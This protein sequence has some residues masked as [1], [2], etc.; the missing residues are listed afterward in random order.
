MSKL[1][2]INNAEN[3]E[4]S[5]CTMYFSTSSFVLNPFQNNKL[6]SSKLKEFADNNSKFDK[7]WH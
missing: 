1:L 5:T 6:D 2:I 7:K 4:D 3:K